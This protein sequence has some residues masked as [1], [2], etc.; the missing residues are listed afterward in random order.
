MNNY[1]IGPVLSPKGI[2]LRYYVD[3]HSQQL[4]FTWSPIASDC[5]AIH[6][7]ILA[8]NCGDCP[9]TTNYTNVTCNN[10]PTDGNTCIFAVQTVFCTN[11][12]SNQSNSVTIDLLIEAK[13]NADGES[14]IYNPCML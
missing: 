2:S 4:T 11:I 12:T 6:Y 8:S 3:L 1:C 7:N 10:V 14:I 13:L 9:T 5:P